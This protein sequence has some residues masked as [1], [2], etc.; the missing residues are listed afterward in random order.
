MLRPLIFGNFFR[1]IRKIKNGLR[2]ICYAPH[3]RRYAAE[4]AAESAVSGSSAR[5]APRGEATKRL[6]IFAEFSSQEK[7]RQEEGVKKVFRTQAT[8]LIRQG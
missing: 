5:K 7:K 6:T 1:N 4:Q 3:H 8:P 2:I